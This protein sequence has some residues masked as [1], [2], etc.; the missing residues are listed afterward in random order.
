MYPTFIVSGAMVHSFPK[1]W[2]TLKL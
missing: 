2:V 1:I